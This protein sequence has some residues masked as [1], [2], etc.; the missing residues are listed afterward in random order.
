MYALRSVLVGMVLLILTGCGTAGVLGTP[1]TVY[2]L[3][4]HP[5]TYA[6]KDVTVIGTYLWKPGNPATAVLLP[7][8][9]TRDG[10]NDA[11]PIFASVAC[12]PNGDCSPE[13]TAV[14]VAETGAVWLEQFPADVSAALHRPSD[15]VWG[16]VEVTGH[17]ETG[18]FGP[19]NA[20]HLRLTVSRARALQSIERIMAT[21][22]AGA[23]GQG[24]PTLRDLAEHPEQYAGK[25][26]TTTG[27]YYWTPATS[28]LLVEQV[29]QE[30]TAEAPTGTNPQPDG[31]I[32]ALDGFPP[33]ISKQ[34]HVG[35]ANSYV[36]GLV[37]LTGR[38]EANGKWGP[39]GQYQTHFVIEDGKVKVLGK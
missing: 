39:Q 5:T 32:I 30:K 21:V 28:G 10:I 23:A 12:T 3:T 26:I 27:Y 16:V 20:Y 38:F 19:K 37:Q 4:Q 22:P 34:L 31:R 9:H 15:S 33:D 14:G 18:Q 17:F 11:Q 6:N 7:G 13:T 1:P 36:W 35:E 8:V 29:A 25:Q 24:Q 2:D